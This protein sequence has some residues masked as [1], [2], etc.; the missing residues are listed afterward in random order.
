MPYPKP[1]DP[2]YCRAS[3]MPGEVTGTKYVRC[4]GDDQ[5]AGCGRLVAT[6]P[7]SKLTFA[8]TVTKQAWDQLHEAAVQRALEETA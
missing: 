7:S 2:R 1:S 3:G 8:H 5:I 6:T 4:V